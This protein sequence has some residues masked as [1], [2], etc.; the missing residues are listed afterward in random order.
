MLGSY[1][2]VF[3]VLQLNYFFKCTCMR[4]LL[5]LLRVLSKFRRKFRRCLFTSP[6]KREIW[7]VVVL[8]WGPTNEPNSMLRVQSCALIA[9]TFCLPSPSSGLKVA[10]Y[11]RRDETVKNTLSGAGTVQAKFIIQRNHY[12]SF[13]SPALK[14]FLVWVWWLLVH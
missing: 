3:T 7:H 10:K 8:S 1:T 9:L 4:T 5:N 2:R 13:S 14:Q 11:T 12:P 6:T